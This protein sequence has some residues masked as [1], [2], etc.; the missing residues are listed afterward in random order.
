VGLRK[1]G[2]GVEGLGGVVG[3]GGPVLGF[4]WGERCGCGGVGFECFFG[5]GGWGV[6]GVGVLGER[7]GV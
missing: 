2:E 3:G 6:F 5:G 4:N 1:K 7:E